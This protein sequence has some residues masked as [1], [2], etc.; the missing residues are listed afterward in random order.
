M[1]SP[2]GCG[3][4]E[5]VFHALTPEHECFKTRPFEHLP[6]NSFLPPSPNFIASRLEAIPI[7]LE[8][9]A[10]KNKGVPNLE[11]VGV[12][13]SHPRPLDGTSQTTPLCDSWKKSHR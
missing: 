3:S 6:L 4:E 11:E 9:I 7:R 1:T 2:N 13:L 12:P 8:A 10:I 5:T